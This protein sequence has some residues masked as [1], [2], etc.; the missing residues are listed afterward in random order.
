[1]I[2]TG[3]RRRGLPQSAGAVAKRVARVAAF[4]TMAAFAAS[5]GQAQPGAACSAGTLYLTLDTGNMRHAEPIAQILAKHQIRATFFLA[6]EKTWQGNTS[7]DPAWDAYWRARADE[8]H[9][10]GSHTWR[11]GRFG[12]D[13]IGPSGQQVSYRPQF[14]DQAGQTLWL[15]APAV[16]TELNRV[17]QAFLR[18]SGRKLD[19]FWRAPGGRTTAFA[20]QAAA[21]CGYTHVHW[22]PAG[23][24]GD[25]LPSESHPN[26]RLVEHALG[27]LRSGDILMAHLGIWSRKDPF[28][29][30]LD[31][32][33]GELKARGY[34]FATLRE[35][36]RAAKSA[37]ASAVQLP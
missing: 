33:L 19:P 18:A 22:S 37:V 3:V 12:A 5:T 11:H 28:A 34:C 9:A 29:P 27:R 21:Q 7:L 23:F 4:V 16:C 36:P 17:Q 13:R 30:M 8:G 25:E 1:M 20:L 15:D 6:D 10:F 2:A 24:L 32:L 31:P 35:H 26:A 14:G